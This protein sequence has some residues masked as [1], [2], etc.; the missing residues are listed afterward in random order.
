MAQPTLLR[1]ASKP[2]DFTTP[3]T[4]SVDLTGAHAILVV[5]HQDTNSSAI[6][7]TDCSISGSPGLV[8]TGGTEVTFNTSSGNRRAFW[9]VSNSIPSGAQTISVTW[10]GTRR[11]GFVVYVFNDAGGSPSISVSASSPTA[12]IG[13]AA[14]QS[15]TVSSTTAAAECLAFSVFVGY[16]GL[17]GTLPA[18]GSG[19]TTAISY[20]NTSLV[21]HAW[22]SENGAAT[23]TTMDWTWSTTG[24]N[25]SVFGFA[26]TGSGGGGGLSSRKLLLG[27]GA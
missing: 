13:T 20:D 9:L 18:T 23:S 26:V 27:V 11:G 4:L 2:H 1:T 22:F 19:G 12:T 14:A 3:A 5:C 15:F 8:F 6:N 7:F 21:N 25:G 10:T 16:Q 17:L 24:N